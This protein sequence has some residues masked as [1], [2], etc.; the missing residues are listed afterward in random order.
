MRLDI[1]TDEEFTKL[2]LDQTKL[3]PSFLKNWEKRFDMNYPYK[4]TSDGKI[5]NCLLQE[6]IEDEY[7]DKYILQQ[8]TK[9]RKSME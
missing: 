6:V 3:Y 2:A 8:A 5:Y 9:I 1:L 4:V 7:C